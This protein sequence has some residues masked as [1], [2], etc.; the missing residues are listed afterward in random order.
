M[1]EHDQVSQAQES[2][3]RAL[4]RARAGEDRDLMQK[5]RERGEQLAHLVSGLVKISR[6]HAPNNR[7]FDQPVGEFARALAALHE[8][9][10]T[11]HL[12]TVED[13]VYVN[14]V[15]V[16]TD[17]K[18]GGSELGNDLRR[19]QAGGLTFHAPLEDPQVRALIA[20]LS[21]S[22]APEAPRAALAANLEKA[23]LSAV[24]VA[25]A[26]QF[27]TE[28]GA[29]ARR[30][31]QDI[32]P[33]TLAL[34]LETWDNLASGRTLNP[35]P[36]RRAVLEIL[37][38]GLETPALW[39]PFPAEAPLHAV[40]AFQVAMVAL[41]TARAAGLAA[42]FVQDLGIAALLHD[43]GYLDP[44]TG[45][46]PEGLARHPFAGARLMLRQKGFHEAKVR[47]LR[48][49]L[50]HHRD[51]AG[52]PAPSAGGALLRI[53]EDYSNLV[54][55]FAERATRAQVLGAM[56][57][58]PQHYSAPLVQL[59]INALGRHPPGT[60]LELEDGRRGRVAAPARS[61]E[62]WERPL[63]RLVDPA[64]GALS[65]QLADLAQGPRVARV[66]LG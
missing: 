4:G 31:Q 25:A 30:P 16:R 42:S 21:A 10:G 59:A 5:V 58:A 60:L 41:L 53:A 15:R 18:T 52:G 8:L 23:G 48:W 51:L 62:L 36:L 33:R 43:C 54:R 3:S 6:V 11:V 50:D 13:Q 47:R 24:E 44:A 1:S 12:V 34:V 2:I 17:P 35:L 56:I 39:G 9:L 19:H 46:G 66:L 65:A 14:D 26:F 40:H 49:L 45:D 22:P 37:E 32:V 57:A 61:P 28:Q 27:R 29:A 20:A 7:A 38:A 63:L 55:V 64:S